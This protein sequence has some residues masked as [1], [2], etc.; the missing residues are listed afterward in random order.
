VESRR[1]RD[2][3]LSAVEDPWGRELTS[4]LAV[5]L[6]QAARIES[7]SGSFASLVVQ[8]AGAPELAADLLRRARETGHESE[9]EGWTDDEMRGH[10]LVEGFIEHH[11]LIWNR[12]LDGESPAEYEDRSRAQLRN[13]LWAA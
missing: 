8:G 11:Q 6:I 13:L 4:A 9:T 10:V 12:V 3:V 2:I 1:A 7:N 5:L